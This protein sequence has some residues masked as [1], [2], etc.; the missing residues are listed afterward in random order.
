MTSQSFTENIHIAILGPVSA[1]KTT[2]LN[3]LFSDTYSDMKR[4]KT[5]MLPQIYQTHINGKDLDTAE[6]IFKKN[7]ESNDAILK[8]R[9]E[10]KYTQKD[11]I[12]LTYNVNSIRDFLKIPDDKA[13][14][15]ILD[16]PG[17][18]CGGGNDMYYNYIKQISHKIDIYILV[19][20]VNSGLNTTDEVKILQV[21]QEEIT[22]NS[23][24][25]VHIL[26]NKCDEVEYQKDNKFTFTDDE[27]EDLYKTCEETAQKY[28]KDIRNKITISP[29]CSSQLYVYRGAMN[30]MDTLEEKQIDNLIK[31]EAG[32]HELKKLNTVEL[33]KKFL[34]GLIKDKKSTLLND[35]M[36]DTGYNL[37]KQSLDD[38]FAHYELMIINHI[39][40]DLTKIN[41]SMI[42]NYD[43]VSNNLEMI[44]KRLLNLLKF[45]KHKSVKDLIAIY[46]LDVLLT[47]ITTKLN[48]FV[49]AGI[50]TYTGNSVENADG[51]LSKIANTFLKGLKN[52]FNSNP[53][54]ESQKKLQDK[55]VLLLNDKLS[56]TGYE[57][58]IFAELYK[59]ETLEQKK[60]ISCIS[61]TLDKKVMSFEKLLES[62][63]KITSNDEVFVTDCIITK[64]I[65][66]YQAKSFEDLCLNLKTTSDI[67]SNNFDVIS[68]IIFCHISKLKDTHSDLY[69]MKNYNYWI[70]LNHANIDCNSK[71]VK[72]IYFQI[73]LLLT[74]VIMAKP[75]TTYTTIQ[76]Y[77]FDEFKAANADMDKVYYTVCKLFGFKTKSL[78]ESKTIDAET[79]DSETEF[80]DAE[81]TETKIKIVN[82]KTVKNTSANSDSD[83]ASYS[84]GDDS[85]NVYKNAKQNTQKRTATRIKKGTQ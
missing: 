69:L 20:D 27:I 18:N 10:N 43:E 22:K 76:Q 2:L 71:E 57:S 16:M 51:F 38:I 44:N 59:N 5:T 77:K 37:F 30:N 11:F 67:T 26:I 55:R 62:V 66:S 12:E 3:S 53:L 46:K 42:T 32:K 9:E 29:L 85:D 80:H 33:K 64:F 70:Q 24:G 65:D 19:F 23:H 74:S 63:T 49:L 68:K 21:V 17:L 41:S 52:M 13:T 48:T 61:I 4:K 25:Y 73:Q 81:T 28:L 39:K 84:E 54:E 47:S 83:I 8:L 79:N 35:W 6:T 58:S 50:D 72:Y 40:M 34:R 56:T 14:Y 45:T 15:S 36:K 31:N 60:Y 78:V 1:G 82:K 7:K 75:N